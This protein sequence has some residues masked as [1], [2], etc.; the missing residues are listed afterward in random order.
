MH[1]PKK[2]RAFFIA[3]PTDSKLQIKDKVCQIFRKY[4]R[5]LQ[6][7]KCLLS[8]ACTWYMK[9]FYFLY[10]LI[11]NSLN[12]LQILSVLVIELIQSISSVQF[13]SVRIFLWLFCVNLR[14]WRSRERWKVSVFHIF[15][16]FHICVSSERLEFLSLRL[17]HMF[18]VHIIDK[19]RMTRSFGNSNIG[20]GA[21][22]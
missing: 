16:I 4:Q 2:T 10:N 20:F 14:A 11:Q 7:N 6:T 18:H 9:I 19:V 12:Y 17:K 13:V 8:P 22:G 15:H 5:S 1:K 21:V 3:A